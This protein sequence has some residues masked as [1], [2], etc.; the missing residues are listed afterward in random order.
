[1]L[2]I[3][4]KVVS[5]STNNNLIAGLAAFFSTYYVFNIKYQPEAEATLEFMQR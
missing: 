3:E 5:V 4:K 2:S 1:M